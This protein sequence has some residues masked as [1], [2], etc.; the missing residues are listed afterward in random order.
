MAINIYIELIDDAGSIEG[1]VNAHIGMFKDHLQ[2]IKPETVLL[3]PFNNGNNY[4][5]PWSQVRLIK[6]NEVPDV[7]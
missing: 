4:A 2:N 5:V 3:F 1:V 7:G 6:Y